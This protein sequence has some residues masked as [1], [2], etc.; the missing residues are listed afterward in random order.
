MVRYADPR[1]SSAPLHASTSNDQP[2]A[3]SASCAVERTCDSP[4]PSVSSV[5]GVGAYTPRCRREARSPLL[6]WMHDDRHARTD[7]VAELALEV[8]PRAR[9]DAV[10][11]SGVHVCSANSA[12]RRVAVA[13]PSHVERRIL[14]ALE[15]HA[16]DQ[17]VR[18]QRFRERDF[19][20]DRRCAGRA[21]GLL[22][23]SA[24]ATLASS[25]R[26]W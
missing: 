4:N 25:T 14:V 1:S 5:S 12:G 9:G 22:R 2:V 8:E 3:C 11:R 13:V 17:D 7:E 26:E 23:T 21:R 24:S 18:S 19:A 10:P 16:R 6:G 20:E 15:R